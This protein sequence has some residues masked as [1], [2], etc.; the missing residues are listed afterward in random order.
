MNKVAIP[1]PATGMPEVDR[2]LGA[3]KQNVD[4]ITGQEKNATKLKPLPPTA[5]TAE[6]I[7]RLNAL[8]ERLQ[9]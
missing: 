1:A 6:Q 7:A 8:L 5:T 9:G 2:V 4:S 3:L